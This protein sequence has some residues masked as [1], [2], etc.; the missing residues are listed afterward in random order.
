MNILI[1]NGRLVSAEKMDN[2]EILITGN[3]I[4]SVKNSFSETELPSDIKIIDAEGKYVMP[5]II[6][7]HTHY[8][9]VSRGTVTADRFFGG[10]VLAAFGGVTTVIDF[11]DHLPAKKIVEGSIYRN[12]EAEGEMAI[13]WALHQVITRVDGDVHK[14][15]EELK[16]LGV[17][18]VKIFTTY[19]SAGYFI[20]KEPVKRIF[21]ACK[22]LGLMVTIHAEDDDIIEENSKQ[23]DNKPYPPELLPVIRS[24][25]A[26]YKAIMEYGE[27][28]GSLD[29]PIYIVHLSSSRGLDAV[30]E[31]NAA[32]VNV[33]VETTPHYLTITNDLLKEEGAQKFLMTPPLRES[34]DNEALWGG[35]ASGDVSIIATDHCTFTE[36]QKLLS[37]D[38]RTIFP[39]IPGT[40]EMLQVIN[41]K[42][43]EKGL[44]DICRLVSL[45]STAPA[46][47]FG[48]YPEKGSLEPG[49]DADIVIFD[50]D[51]ESVL[52]NDNRHTAAGYTPYDGMKVK[53]KAETVI[54]RG[55]II[56]KD[57]EFI[58][59]KGAGKFLAAG[60]PG[61]YKQ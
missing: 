55:E 28:A 21:E 22:D 24:S 39:G 59:R 9:L 12:S 16:A 45:L 13:D 47:A 25:E 8:Q 43:V 33:I 34:A 2:K 5:G 3:K 11:S 44:F 35:V 31:L 53:G 50:P 17:T 18:A 15:L 57:G 46:K 30:R 7:A 14:E 20:E 56:L 37:D 42:G 4:K 27:I 60:L 58:G 19:K 10:S 23:V 38:C 41:T 32:G 54:L 36:E 40:E 6:D 1:K 26:E 51:A 49:T 61:A 48:L 29:M 52:R